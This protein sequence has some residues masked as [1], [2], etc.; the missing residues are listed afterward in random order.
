MA[1][2]AAETIFNIGPF[3]I[4]NTVLDTLLVDAII[5]GGVFYISKKLKLVPTNPAA[6]VINTFIKNINVDH[7]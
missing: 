3:P 4:T 6:P 7:F 2:F 5:I 1:S